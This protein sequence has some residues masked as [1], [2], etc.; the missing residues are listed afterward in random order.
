MTTDTRLLGEFLKLKPHQTILDVGT[1]N[2]ALLLYCLAFQ[3]R[4]LI[5]VDVNPLGLE[6]A[7]QTMALHHVE[8]SEW[9]EGDF[10]S[11]NRPADVIICN[12]PYFRES[13]PSQVTHRNIAMHDTDH[14]IDDLFRY[15]LTYLTDQGELHLIYP[16]DEL[17][18]LIELGLSAGLHVKRMQFAYK[19]SKQV[20]HVVMLAFR[21]NARKGCVVEMPVIIR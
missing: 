21:K 12:P 5:G 20:A 13:T 9:I 4:A 1:N 15:A 6:L 7:R 8:C 10:R 14:F 2:G 18:G 3:P 16:A 17:E 11:I 19:S